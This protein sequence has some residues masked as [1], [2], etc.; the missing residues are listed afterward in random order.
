MEVHNGN[1]NFTLYFGIAIDFQ[2]ILSVI[3]VVGTL[4]GLVVPTSTRACPPPPSQPNPPTL[5]PPR[6]PIHL[7]P[8]RVRPE[9]VRHHPLRLSHQAFFNQEGAARVCWGA[10]QRR[11]PMQN[12]RAAELSIAAVSHASIVQRVPHRPCDDTRS[13]QAAALVFC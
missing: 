12:H 6:S 5:P 1:C 4:F 10:G 8:K 7:R 9:P 13:K 2:M 11:Q 3:T